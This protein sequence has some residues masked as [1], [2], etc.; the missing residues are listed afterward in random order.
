MFAP[1]KPR[2]VLTT[3][4]EWL[5]VIALVLFS[6]GL[7]LAAC[8]GL[9]RLPNPIT[10]PIPVKVAKV[11]TCDQQNECRVE[12]TNGWR[13]TVSEPVAVGDNYMYHEWSDPHDPNYH[14][15]YFFEGRLNR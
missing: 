14:P 2:K 8:Y 11:L 1:L 4:K 6:V 5:G 7:V 13:H 9:N 3:L 12:F 15:R 10:T